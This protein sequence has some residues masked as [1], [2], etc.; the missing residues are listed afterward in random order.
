MSSGTL[1][2]VAVVRTNVSENISPPSSGF[3]RVRGFHSCVTMESLLINLSR[4]GYYVGSKKTVRWD[5][6][7]AVSM[8]DVFWDSVIH[9]F[10]FCGKGVL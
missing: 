3:L 9:V 6:F 5:A 10:G 1:Y 8:I 7:R 2:H 4:D